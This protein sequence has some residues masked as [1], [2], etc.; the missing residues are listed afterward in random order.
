MQA[1]R[2]IPLSG[3]SDLKSRGEMLLLQAAEDARPAQPAHPRLSDHLIYIPKKGSPKPYLA[4][5]Q[6]LGMAAVLRK[7]VLVVPERVA[8]EKL[9]QRKS[10][11]GSQRVGRGR[12]GFVPEIGRYRGKSRYLP[13]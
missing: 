7:A 8:A 4:S 11:G 10:K 1:G 6:P 5:S 9:R 3:G 13:P 2:Y 12:V